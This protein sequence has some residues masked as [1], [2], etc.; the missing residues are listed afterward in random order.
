MFSILKLHCTIELLI[1]APG[2]TIQIKTIPIHPKLPETFSHRLA[3]SKNHYPEFKNTFLRRKRT[4]INK[5]PNLMSAHYKTK[6]IKPKHTHEKK[7][8]NTQV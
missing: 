4:Q 5:L 8:G 2:L 3:H 7:K 1:P 6:N